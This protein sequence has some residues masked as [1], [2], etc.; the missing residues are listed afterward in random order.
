MAY[1]RKRAFFNHDQQPRPDKIYVGPHNYTAKGVVKQGDLLIASNNEAIWAWDYASAKLEWCYEKTMDRKDPHYYPGYHSSNFYIEQGK[2]I[3]PVRKLHV[4]GYYYPAYIVVLDAQTGKLEHLFCDNST[5][6]DTAG[7][8]DALTVVSNGQII[9]SQLDGLI[10][11]YDCTF[12]SVYMYENP[13][14]FTNLLATPHHI[15]AFTDD[16][17]AIY[18]RTEGTHKSVIHCKSKNG[19]SWKMCSASIHEQYMICGALRER[20]TK[21]AEDFMIIDLQKR[22]IIERYSADYNVLGKGN[23]HSIVMKGQHVFY[24]CNEQ[25]FYSNREGSVPI[26]LENVAHGCME[27]QL[28]IKDNYL[29]VKQGKSF[30]EGHSD[31]AIWN[32]ETRHKVATIKDTFL[33]KP[34]LEGTHLFTN[35]GSFL[36]RYAMDLS[37]ICKLEDDLIP[38]ACL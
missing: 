3:C 29:L 35:Q 18:N 14:R 33:E 9:T 19:V 25:L 11:C 30:E 16:A 1:A 7:I 38:K 27:N 13:F 20:Y 4:E 22:Q 6:R 5:S 17:I 15:A 24:L 34:V 31:L 32:I 21:N 2:V 8:H 37:P 10:H 28:F 26:F 12:K 23:I 36:V